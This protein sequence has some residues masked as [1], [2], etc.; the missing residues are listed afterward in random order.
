M[1]EQVFFC[2]LSGYYIL[3]DRYLPKVEKAYQK[4]EIFLN[5]KSRGPLYC[6]DLAS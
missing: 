1:A 3:S 5:A 4:Q 6:L 2:L